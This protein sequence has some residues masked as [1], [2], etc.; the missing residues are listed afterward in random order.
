MSNLSVR[1]PPEVTG[2]L[3]REAELSGKSRSDLVREAV[4]EYV[5][6]KQRERLVSELA[7]EMRRAYADAGTRRES[8]V[9][10][11]DTAA[12]GLAQIVADEVAAGF[13]PSERWW[14]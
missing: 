12:D 6:R 11:T 3:D 10:A 2:E 1:L 5:T 4:G 7:E 8:L 13:K 9:L 14:K